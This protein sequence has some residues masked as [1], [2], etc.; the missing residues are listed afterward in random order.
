MF[1][2]KQ[3]GE[4]Q[5]KANLAKG[6]AD[7]GKNIETEKKYPINSKEEYESTKAAVMS[8]AQKPGFE[9]QEEEPRDR[10][11]KYLDTQDKQFYKQGISFS[12]RDRGKDRFVTIK[13]PTE[14]NDTRIEYEFS[15]GEKG[16]DQIKA[17]DI[18]QT[19]RDVATGKAAVEGFTK[20]LAIEL[21]N[22]FENRTID[23]KHIDFSVTYVSSSQRINVAHKDLPYGKVEIAVDR[24]TP[25][26]SRG[27]GDIAEGKQR[28]FWEVEIEEKADKK[29]LKEI[30]DKD[31][32]KK[33]KATMIE[34]GDEIRK[35]ILAELPSGIRPATA[36]ESNKY[37]RAVKGLGEEQVVAL[38]S[39]ASKKRVSELL[40]SFKKAHNISSLV[41]A[42]RHL[43][44]KF[45]DQ[46]R[47]EGLISFYD[48]NSKDSK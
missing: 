39:V 22:H 45:I 32:A 11:W 31:E 47:K 4:T 2:L 7:A 29:K 35:T 18:T 17:G 46:L 5:A 44:Q 6:G 28:A 14:K 9:I 12:V 48:P 43:F 38:D 8:L 27:K 30:T 33:L 34:Q 25:V 20:E 42:P 1:L 40:E 10:V 13:I 21:I 36:D 26:W 15:M 37:K 23:L 16:L 24:F 3:V 41:E 19:I